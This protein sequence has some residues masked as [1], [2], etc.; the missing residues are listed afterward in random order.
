LFSNVVRIARYSLKSF[1]ALLKNFGRRAYSIWQ[2]QILS[3]PNRTLKNAS[4]VSLPTWQQ[5]KL[6][7][8]ILTLQEKK[9]LVISIL[10]IFSSSLILGWHWFDRNTNIVPASGG[11]Y[12]EGIIGRPV[13]THPL[14]AHKP[15]E[16]DLATLTYRGLFKHDENGLLVN[17]LTSDWK[18]INNK[19]TYQITLRPDLYWSDGKNITSND[20]VFTFESLRNETLQSP[21]AKI[22]QNIT[23]KATDDKTVE[24]TLTQPYSAFLKTLTFGI[25]PSHIWKDIAPKD[26]RNSKYNIEAVGSGPFRF[27]SFTETRQGKISSYNLEPNPFS[28]TVKPYLNKLTLRF[29]DD[30]DAGLEA[31]KQGVID[32]LGGLSPTSINQLNNQ[33]TNILTL[34]LPQY[35]ALFYNS[36]STPVLQRREIRQAL[37]QAINRK[38]II[39]NALSGHAE[40]LSSPFDFNPKDVA[41][42]TNQL[43]TKSGWAKKDGILTN[44]DGTTLDITLTA[45]NDP[46]QARVANNIAEE[47]RILGARVNIELISN[48]NLWQ[49]I[50]SNKKYQILLAT[51]II[52]ADFDLYPFWHSSQSGQFGSNLAIFKNYEADQI[53]ESVHQI[54]NQ[55]DKLKKYQRLLEIFSEELPASFLYKE[56]YS[57]ALAKDVKITTPKIIDQPNDR[58]INIE[59]W[60][61]NTERKWK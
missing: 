23:I 2:S 3:L 53:L 26:W 38:K 37:D 12:S 34:D 10:L 40:P 59:Y 50:L 27:Q 19:K 30:T 52:G 58:F 44:K 57:Y 31:L 32:G 39:L 54:D 18:L 5:F 36:N 45:T 9:L 1:T 20:I 4:R 41:T 22:F 17:D 60:Y 33:E 47:W 14:L 7:P 21:L 16:L 42:E 8:R 56:N 49:D 48:S 55:T 29:Y 51:E 24:I 11:E 6:L 35:T 46:E 13:T 28:H 15:A 43:L 25:I 61:R